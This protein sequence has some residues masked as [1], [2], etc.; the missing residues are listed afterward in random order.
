MNIE[1]EARNWLKKR[2]IKELVEFE[3]NGKKVKYEISTIL[4]LV[5]SIKRSVY[6]E[7]G[8]YSG[9]YTGTV[10]SFVNMEEL[11]WKKD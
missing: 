10:E 8:E 5:A 1:K 3:E 4:N 9:W 7:D 11:K 6:L 2:N